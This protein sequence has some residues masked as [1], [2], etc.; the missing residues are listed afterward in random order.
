MCRLRESRPV[1]STREAFALL[2]MP[3]CL[4]SWS[5]RSA[6]EGRSVLDERGYWRAYVEFGRDRIDPAAL[7]AEGQKILGEKALARLEQTVKRY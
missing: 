2:A 1:L 4:L 3:I 5:A 6:E 7:K